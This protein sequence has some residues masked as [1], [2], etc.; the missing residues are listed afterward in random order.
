MAKVA[1]RAVVARAMVAVARPVGEA[2]AARAGC[3]GIVVMN[4]ARGN[5]FDCESL[6]LGLHPKTALRFKAKYSKDVPLA[7]LQ[8]AETWVRDH[9]AFHLQREAQELERLRAR[10]GAVRTPASAAGGSSSAAGGSS[11]N[12]GAAPAVGA[13]SAA[14][15]SSATIGPS[16]R[17]SMRDD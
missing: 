15:S 6:A 13:A 11:S 10:T 8:S 7:R 16:T 14:G 1:M 2:L 17:F 4:N 3:A 9:K 5:F 12:G